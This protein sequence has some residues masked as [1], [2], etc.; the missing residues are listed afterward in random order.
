[1]EPRI[2]FAGSIK[3]IE[4]TDNFIVGIIKNLGGQ[5]IRYSQLLEVDLFGSLYNFINRA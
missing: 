5:H 4:G 3:F 1:M 2:L